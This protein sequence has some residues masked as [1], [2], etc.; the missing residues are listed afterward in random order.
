M[1]KRN[2]YT[3]LGRT[4]SHR[5]TLVRN[6]VRSIFSSGSIATTTSKAKVLRGEVLSLLAAVKRMEPQSALRLVKT[7]FVDRKHVD[8]VINYANAEKSRISLIGYEVEKKGTKLTAESTDKKAKK[9]TNVKTEPKAKVKTAGKVAKVKA[10]TVQK[11]R[12][13]TRAGI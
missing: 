2:G 7:Y 11:E 6:L 10:V 9:V 12:A 13:R 4:T 3:K 5:T 1:L 8:M